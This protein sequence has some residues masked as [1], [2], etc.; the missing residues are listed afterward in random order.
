MRRTTMV[1][2]LAAVALALHAP[3]ALAERSAFDGPGALRDR[4][5]QSRRQMLS[6]FAI[7]PWAYGLG[8]GA[9]GRF[10]LPLLKDGF[11]PEANDSFEFEAG[12][13]WAFSSYGCVGTVCPTFHA[14]RPLAGVRWTFHFTPKLSAYT[15]LALGL[16][17]YPAGFAFAGFSTW[18]FFFPHF[19]G[20]L[21][22]KLGGG[23]A[24]R[25]EL[26]FLGLY[27]GIGID[28]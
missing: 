6:V 19:A 5:P 9:G 1:L 20:G 16:A 4:S 8:F 24:L 27:G 11:I 17:I 22:Y 21:L 10:S 25:I 3:P 13:E 15:M 28:L 18:G 2:S 7:L 12:V 23:V 26:G 14:I